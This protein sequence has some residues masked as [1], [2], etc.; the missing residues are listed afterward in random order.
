MV[1]GALDGLCHGAIRAQ[2]HLQGHGVGGTLA[3]RTVHGVREGCSCGLCSASVPSL[4]DAALTAAWHSTMRVPPWARPVSEVHGT[5][6][7]YFPCLNSTSV[8]NIEEKKQLAMDK[9][10]Y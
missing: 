4:T 6:P 10:T 9:A 1:T 8:L 3:S 2:W 7:H 5:V